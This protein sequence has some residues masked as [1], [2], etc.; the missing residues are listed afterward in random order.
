[1]VVV[2]AGDRRQ[3][4]AVRVRGRLVVEARRYLE[5]ITLLSRIAQLDQPTPLRTNVCAR[6][7]RTCGPQGGSPGLTQLRHRSARPRN[8]ISSILLGRPASWAK[9]KVDP[10]Q[11]DS[12][13]S[14]FACEPFTK[15][16]SK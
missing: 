10:D 9:R 6:R 2:L 7:K 3:R 5:A 16:R 12:I 13:E 8:L 4:L 14:V 11:H 15:R 1:V